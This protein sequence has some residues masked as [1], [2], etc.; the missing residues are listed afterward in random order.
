MKE[1]FKESQT[2]SFYRLVMPKSEQ[3]EYYRRNL[4]PSHL[5]VI[6]YN[7]AYGSRDLFFFEISTVYDTATS[8]S[9]ELLIL[10]GKGKIINQSLHHLVHQ[11]DFY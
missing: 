7:L 9:E 11:L 8:Q 5:E 3:H 4:V 10:S 6:K 1:E 2:E